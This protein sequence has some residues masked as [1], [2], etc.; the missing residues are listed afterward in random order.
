MPARSE[1]F[2]LSQT[3][4]FEIVWPGLCELN[5]QLLESRFAAGLWV[6]RIENAH[7][8]HACLVRQPATDSS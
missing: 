5:E 6:Q 8:P 1:I 4:L 3:I 7:G 2:V